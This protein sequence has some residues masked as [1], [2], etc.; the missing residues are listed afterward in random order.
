MCKF[1]ESPNKW[2]GRKGHKPEAIVIHITDGNSQGAL[3]WLTNPVSQVSAHF[4]IDEA[5]I[6]WQLVDCADTAWH[7][8]TVVRSTWPLLKQ[9]INPNYY[10]IGIEIAGTPDK[11]PATCQIIEAANLVRELAEKYSIPLDNSHIIPHNSIRADKTCPGPYIR[12][13][14]ILDLASLLA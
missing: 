2:T 10:T 5:G 1:K 14:T 3:A 7:A 8:G 11:K 13:S 12:I 6:R 9:G 4:L